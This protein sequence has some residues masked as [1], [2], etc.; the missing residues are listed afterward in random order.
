MLRYMMLPHTDAKRA[1]E[2]G[3]PADEGFTTAEQ[4]QRAVAALGA[5]AK[6]TE[7]Q[8]PEALK[9][10][11]AELKW[12]LALKDEEHQTALARKDEEIMQLRRRLPRA[13]AGEDGLEWKE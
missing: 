11:I 8:V 13:S 6:T 10:E 12:T 2:W 3:E 1:T 4:E 5:A 7:K 9:A